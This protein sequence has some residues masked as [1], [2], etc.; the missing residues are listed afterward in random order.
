MGYH[1]QQTLCKLCTASALKC[2]KDFKGTFNK[3]NRN[4]KKKGTGY[5]IFLSIFEWSVG[6]GMILQPSMSLPRKSVHDLKPQTGTY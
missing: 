4:P 2:L 6:M 3:L 5:G 1:K